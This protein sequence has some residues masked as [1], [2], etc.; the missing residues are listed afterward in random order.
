VEHGIRAGG[1]F[2]QPTG[3][4][5]VLAS[6][7][8]QLA[9]EK[10]GMIISM[11]PQTANIGATSGF[12]DTWG[13]Y[14][15]LIMQTYKV[16]TWVGIQLYNTGCVYGIDQV[17]YG[18][19]GNSPD[20]SVAMATDLLADWPAKLSTGQATGFQPYISYLNP[21]Q[22]VLGYPAPNNQGISDGLPVT[23]NTLI[24]RAIQCLR[25]GASCGSYVPPKTY[26]NIGGVFNWEVTYDQANNFQ[27]ANGLKACVKQ[28]NCN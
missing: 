24:K 20:F 11:A 6:I 15:S 4:I 21:G 2:A 8:K 26:P 5:A 7:M 17:C 9:A 25:T 18:N 10:P 23:P 19:L 27:F 12:N 13:N 28:G 3:D 16:L 14:A 22:V 1:T